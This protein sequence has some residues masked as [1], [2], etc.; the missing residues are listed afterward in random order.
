MA[1]VV[2]KSFE[3]VDVDKEDAEGPADFFPEGKE[4][5]ELRF[6]MGS[7]GHFG[8]GVKE[9]PPLQLFHPEADIF[10]GADL[11]KDLDSSD[12]ISVL[13]LEWGRPHD[14]GTRYPRR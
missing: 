9:G 10:L 12:H 1:M 6:E 5:F 8:Q 11:G 3:M 7:R 2:V 13:I 14:T 4:G